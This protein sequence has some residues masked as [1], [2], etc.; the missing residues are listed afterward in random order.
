MLLQEH[1]LLSFYLSFLSTIHPDFFAFGTSAVDINTDILV[2]SPYGGTGILYRK[3]LAKHIK[4]VET[5]NVR[6]NGITLY[7]SDGPMLIV[8][9]MLLQTMEIMIA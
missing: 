8:C 2:G 9:V 6:L 4:P 7:T 1:W 5:D 3:S